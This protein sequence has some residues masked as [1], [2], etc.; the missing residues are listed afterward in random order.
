MDVQ[1]WRINNWKAEYNRPHFI[2][3]GF[4]YRAHKIFKEIFNK[5]DFNKFIKKWIK[6]NHD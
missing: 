2:Y 1:W 4:K 5:K 6:K 3:K